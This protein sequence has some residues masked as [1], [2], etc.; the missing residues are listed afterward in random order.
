MHFS[1]SKNLSFNLFFFF[2]TI[3]AFLLCFLLVY[4]RLSFFF[5]LYI[6][7]R[8]VASVTPVVVFLYTRLKLDLLHCKNIHYI[9]KKSFYANKPSM[10]KTSREVA[11][12][13]KPL[14]FI[15]LFCDAYI[16]LLLFL[17]LGKSK[18]FSGERVS[19]THSLYHSNPEQKNK[20]VSYCT[21]D[22]INN[23][24]TRESKVNRKGS[25]SPRT[26]PSCLLY[27]PSL[28]LLSTVIFMCTYCIY[29]YE[30]LHTIYYIK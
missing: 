7:R 26:R 27:F 2:L 20:N 11:K 8:V 22:N 15:S 1:S 28:P 4:L 9:K 13:K 12:D 10:K 25:E 24:N 21:T 16:F 14:D 18:S 3:L 6:A 5:S 19:A 30:L 17:F 29:V 23:N